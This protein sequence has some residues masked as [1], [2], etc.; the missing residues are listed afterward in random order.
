M[1]K[2]QIDLKYFKQKLLDE[3]KKLLERIEKLEKE[4]PLLILGTSGG[5]R[6]TYDEESTNVV[7]DVPEIGRMTALKVNIEKQLEQIDKA[8]LKIKKKTYGKCEICKQEISITRLKV[9]PYA[10]LCV[11]CQQKKEREG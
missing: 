6:I 3:K 10:T 4:K 9:I 2:N 8:L 5:D 7:I 1:K 11:K